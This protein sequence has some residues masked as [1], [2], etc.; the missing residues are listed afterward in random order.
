MSGRSN[1]APRAN[2][3]ARHVIV[4]LALFALPSGCAWSRPLTGPRAI[5]IARRSVC[6]SPGSATDTACTVRTATP[7]RDGYRV[8]LDRRPP[9][10]N[11]RVTVL[12]RGGGSVV[13]VSPLDTPR[14]ARAEGWW[15]RVFADTALFRQVCMEADSG[16][17]PTTAGRCTPR[18]QRLTPESRRRR[19]R[20]P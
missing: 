2:Y 18:D 1:G 7:E 10:G 6:G 4:A 11:D 5:E 19:A 12:V 16:L 17:T 9:A 8:V 3:I 15:A 14:A 13:E 20:D